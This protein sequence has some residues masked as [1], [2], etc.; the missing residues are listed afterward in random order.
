ML[1]LLFVVV[2]PL[3]VSG[4]AIATGL[5]TALSAGLVLRRLTKDTLFCLCFRP[6]SFAHGAIGEI[7]KTGVPSAVQGAVFC[8]ANLFVQA[9]VNAFGPTAIAGSTIALNFE[10]FTYYCTTA[11]GQ[12]VT[13]FISQNHAAGQLARCKKI[14]RLCLLFST[15]CSLLMIGPIVLFRNAFCRLFTADPLVVQSACVRIL[16]ILFYEPVCNLYEIPAGA[17][18][19]AG[20]PLLPAASMIVGTCAFRILWICTVFAAHPALSTLYH[21]FPLSWLFTICLVALSVCLVRPFAASK[22]PRP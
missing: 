12:T 20:H 14:L 15:L 5:S 10:Y 6:L 16:C 4:V 8:F 21:A 13:T 19:G 2:F 9:S 11:F 18:R 1:N 3:G 22:T 17:L 7:L